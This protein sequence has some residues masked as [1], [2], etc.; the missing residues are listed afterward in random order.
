MARRT[1][2]DSRAAIFRAAALEFA[3][4]GYEAAGTDR[5]ATRARVNKAMLYYHFGSK[6]ELYLEVVRDMFGR[7]RVR[8]RAPLPTVPGHRRAKLDC[9]DQPRSSKK[10]PPGRG[11]RRSCCASW[12]R[13][14]RIS[15]PRPFHMM[16][17]VLAGVT[18][19]IAQGQREGAF[20]DVDP[21]LRISRSCRRPHLLRASAR[22]GRPEAPR[23]TRRAASAR[24]VRSSYAGLRER[25]AAERHHDRLS[26][27]RARWCPA[28]PG[29]VR[30][31]ADPAIDCASPDTSRRPKSTSLP[32]S[33]AAFSSCAWT[34]A[35]AS[36]PAT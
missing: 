17:A 24:P 33:V 20:R 1:M 15:T 8:A 25:H 12:P 13:A 32:K 7:G 30:A 26:S 21:L 5:I 27:A 34:K 23:R 10:P 31:R 29:G 28:A 2:R 11:S 4:R 36:R 16:N 22:P 19:V 6:G 9:V 14:R 18:D 35:I 3:E